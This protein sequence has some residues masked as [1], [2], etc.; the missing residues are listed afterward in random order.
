MINGSSIAKNVLESN[1]S[2][3]RRNTGI[4]KKQ[5]TNDFEESQYNAPLSNINNS[6]Y[7]KGV[8]SRRN[9][10]ADNVS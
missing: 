6:F 10:K 4:L 2:I 3:E 7:N 8:N 1:N 5:K 9:S